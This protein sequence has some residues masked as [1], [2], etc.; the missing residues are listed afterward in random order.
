MRTVTVLASGFTSAKR[1]STQHDSG[2][3]NRAGELREQSGFSEKYASTST[4][5]PSDTNPDNEMV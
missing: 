5:A 2:A 3:V 4:A 1:S